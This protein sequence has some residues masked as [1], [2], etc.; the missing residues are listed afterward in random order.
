MTEYLDVRCD[1]GS[2]N[3]KVAMGQRFFQNR[4]MCYCDD[5]QA[6]VRHLGHE[7]SLNKYGGTDVYQVSASQVSI[8]S[9]HEHVRCLKVTSKGVHRWYAGC[10]N[11]PIG[12]TI[13]ANWPLVGLISSSIVQDLDSTVGPIKGSVFCKFANQPIPKEVKGPRSHKQ[14]VAMMI[15]KLLI[16]RALGKARPNPFYRDGK[17]IS[18][19]ICLTSEKG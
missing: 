11:S 19:P 17:A 9:G 4:V 13:N 15:I 18:K 1:C 8:V 14:I 7:K 6:F 12:N 5:C 10:C 16:W 3:G 2:V